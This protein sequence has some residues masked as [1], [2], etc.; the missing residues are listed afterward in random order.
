MS[1]KSVIR[2]GSPFTPSD[3]ESLILRGMKSRYSLHRDEIKFYAGDAAYCPRRA[4]KFLVTDKM[5]E[6][7]PSSVMYMK[8]GNAI[9]NVITDALHTAGVLI[10]KEFRLPPSSEPDIRGLIDA[11]IFAA[12]EGVIGLEIKS[13]G[14]LPAKPKDDHVAQASVYSALSG[15]DIQI[16]YVSRKVAGYDG[17]LIMK[18]FDLDLTPSDMMRVLSK[19]CL[20][21]Y[22]KAEGLLPP[23]PFGFRKEQECGFC[24]FADECF[25][26]TPE[27]LPT[28]WGEKLEALTDKADARALE[29]LDDR[30]NRRNG[31]LKHIQRYATEDVAKRLEVIEW[32]PKIS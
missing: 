11:I 24:P 3:T 22:A 23:I 25:D 4:V 1:P 20:A 31:I 7:G 21:H 13:C 26:G 27:A 8:M 30:L 32:G 29:I 10:F 12:P 16:V 19:V 6:N 9:H 5:G 18:S 17:K 15:L 14:N 2:R 28:A